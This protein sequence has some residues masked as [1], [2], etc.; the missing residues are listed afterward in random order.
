VY[1]VIHGTSCS[2]LLQNFFIRKNLLVLILIC[3]SF[4]VLD[5]SVLCISVFCNLLPLF[6]DL[7]INIV[8]CFSC[9][10]I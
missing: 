9:V 1:C 3:L 8:F 6:G 10:R 5:C 2:V 7:I 4:S